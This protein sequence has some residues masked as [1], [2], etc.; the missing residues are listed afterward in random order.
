MLN[1]MSSSGNEITESISSPRDGDETEN[2]C[3][4]QSP[5]GEETIIICKNPKCGGRRVCKGCLPGSRAL[6]RC[7]ICRVMTGIK[8]ARNLRKEIRADEEK[9]S[10]KT[11]QL[12]ESQRL[13]EALRSEEARLLAEVRRLEEAQR[14]EESRW[15][16]FKD[17]QDSANERI[18]VETAIMNSIADYDRKQTNSFDKKQIDDAIKASLM[19]QPSRKQESKQTQW[20]CSLC[21]FVNNSSLG[22]CEIC[23]DDNPQ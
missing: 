2:C 22:K 1:N 14:L 9:V 6:T 4:C 5:H 18:R 7:P 8:N 12:E 17:L 20:A 3:L 19:K 23:G 21:T 16:E 11:I 15:R 10:F 13:A